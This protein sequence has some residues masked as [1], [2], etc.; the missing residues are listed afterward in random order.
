MT[1]V[2]PDNGARSVVSGKNRRGRPKVRRNISIM[3]DGWGAEGTAGRGD[4]GIR[5]AVRVDRAMWIAGSSGGPTAL[6]AFIMT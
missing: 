6:E 2:A 1:P 4:A 5:F 3:G